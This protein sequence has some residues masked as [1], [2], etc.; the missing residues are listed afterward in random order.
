[1][2]FVELN[3]FLFICL[4]VIEN[5][6]SL[7]VHCLG[8]NLVIL[9]IFNKDSP[10]IILK[11]CIEFVTLVHSLN[12]IFGHRY[13]KT[14]FQINWKAAS[15]IDGL[16]K[17][18]FRLLQWKYSGATYRPIGPVYKSVKT[19]KLFIDTPSTTNNTFVCWDINNPSYLKSLTKITYFCIE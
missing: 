1:M 12:D 13:R 16:R 15:T 9:T 8:W 2:K 3:F 7:A 11:K 17:L 19:R 5:Y 18:W 6:W 14:F 4:K 10:V